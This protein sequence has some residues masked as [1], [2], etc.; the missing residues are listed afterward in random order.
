MGTDGTHDSSSREQ[1]TNMASKLY[2]LD[3]TPR[4]T[5]FC[6]LYDCDVS[7]VGSV[8]QSL[9]G[10][11][12]ACSMTCLVP[13]A[14]GVEERWVID[15][16][17]TIDKLLERVQLDD[18]ELDMHLRGSSQRPLLVD[19]QCAGLHVCGLHTCVFMSPSS[20]SR[21]SCPDGG[22][23]GVSCRPWPCH[24]LF[25]DLE[26]SNCLESKHSFECDVR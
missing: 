9:P 3:S 5:P 17:L 18:E 15:H 21:C 26:F 12:E 14:N 20:S 25:T 24:A 1:G 8:L 4:S 13:G 6:V 19:I 11:R 23:S 7:T 10:P 16:K 2:I 22:N